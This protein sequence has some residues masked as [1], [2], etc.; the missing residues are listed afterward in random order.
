[1]HVSQNDAWSS[2][3]TQ[4]SLQLAL[5]H[6]SASHGS[7]VVVVVVVVDVGACVVVVVVVVSG[8]QVNPSP[9]KPT[10]HA[11]V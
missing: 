8:T 3:K 5:E 10:L 7:T 11:Q 2:Q 1:M 6:A 4:K 9:T